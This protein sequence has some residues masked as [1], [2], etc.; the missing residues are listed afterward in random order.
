MGVSQHRDYW[1][2]IGDTHTP[3]EAVLTDAAGDAIDL[4]GASSA[5]FSMRLVGASSSKVSGAA[6][7]ILDDG[8]TALRGRVRYAW[9]SGNV[10][11]AG[12][13]YGEFSVSWVGAVDT[14]PRGLKKYLLI[15][16]Q[17]KL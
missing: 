13:Y 7:T 12:D 1:I 14:F 3:L 17:E 4:S 5:T 2:K 16:I 15:Q 11:T 9:Q 8:S 10:D 6:A